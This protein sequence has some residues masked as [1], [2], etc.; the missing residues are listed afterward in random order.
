MYDICL[1]LLS[2]FQLATRVCPAKPSRRNVKPTKANHASSSAPTNALCDVDSS[3]YADNTSSFPAVHGIATAVEQS[4]HDALQDPTVAALKRNLQLD[5]NFRSHGT[6]PLT[7]QAPL[8]SPEPLSETSSLASYG[9]D[10]FYRQLSG[11]RRWF[12]RPAMR[13]DPIKQSPLCR[14]SPPT[15]RLILSSSQSGA[16]TGLCYPLQEIQQSSDAKSE[17]EDSGCSVVQ[18]VAATV[19]PSSMHQT[20]VEVH[21]HQDSPTQNEASKSISDFV[22]EQTDDNTSA[23]ILLVDTTSVQAMSSTVSTDRHG[24]LHDDISLSDGHC[25]QAVTEYS[26]KCR[27][28]ATIDVSNSEKVDGDKCSCNLT[29]HNMSMAEC[30]CS[31]VPH[32]DDSSNDICIVNPEVML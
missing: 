10:S 2:A 31:E 15:T 4:T 6:E 1:V 20:V 29:E 32:L 16:V 30:Q 26:S 27:H 5:V 19:Q 13:M 17:E 18:I 7:A 23:D 24:V 28:S 21:H 3:C 9:S 22:S 25:S 14:P 11:D 12:G 8:A